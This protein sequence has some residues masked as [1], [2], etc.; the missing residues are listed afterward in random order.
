MWS[1]RSQ[2]KL[3]PTL[4]FCKMSLFSPTLPKAQR[5][6]RMTISHHSPELYHPSQPIPGKGG[7]WKLSSTKYTQGDMTNVTI[8]TAVTSYTLI[9]LWALPPQL[10]MMSSQQSQNLNLVS[11][12]PC[13]LCDFY[14]GWH[15]SHSWSV[16]KILERSCSS[17]QSKLVFVWMA[18]RCVYVSFGFQR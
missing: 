15:C 7:S 11:P 10:F 16:T 1:W 4:L 13:F 5:S 14:G 2:A 9:T 17:Q 12:W 8:T 6:L 18:C 3:S